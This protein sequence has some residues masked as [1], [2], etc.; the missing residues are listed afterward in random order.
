MAAAGL[1]AASVPVLAAVD[2]RAPGATVIGG[3]YLAERTFGT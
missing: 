1:C 3:C 2:T